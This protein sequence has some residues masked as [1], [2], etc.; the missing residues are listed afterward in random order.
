MSAMTYLSKHPETGVYRF[1]RGIPPALRKAIGRGLEWNE[2]LGTKD[3][4]VAKSLMPEVTERVNHAFA[5]VEATI[6]GAGKG[7]E[8]FDTV[9]AS[10]AKQFAALWLSERMDD[11][12]DWR[13]EN[14]APEDYDETLSDIYSR[15]REGLND[16]PRPSSLRVV[17]RDI[18]D[19]CQK[20]ELQLKMNSIGYRRIGHALLLNQRRWLEMVRDRNAGEWPEV[21]RPS[22][23]PARRQSEPE[24]EGDTPT[25]SAVLRAW[26]AERKP[27]P[28]TEQEWTT[29]VRRWKDLHG[30]TPVA[31]IKKPMVAAFKDELLKAPARPPHAIRALPLPKMVKAAAAKDLR[32]VSATAV[33]KTLAAI[34]SILSYAIKQGQ[35][36]VNPASGVLALVQRTSEDEERQSFTDAQVCMVLEAALKEKRESDRWLPWMAALMGAR[37]DEMATPRAMD[38]MTEDGIAYLR[39]TDAGEGRSTKNRGSRRKMPIHPFL[40][41]MGFLDYVKGLPQDGPLFPGLNSKAYTPRFGR[42]LD[43]IG[44]DDPNL[45]FHSFRH[46]FKDACRTAGIQEEVHDALTGHSNVSVGRKYGSRGMPVDIL[47]DAVNSVT[48]RGLEAIATKADAAD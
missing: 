10:D 22:R 17:E 2:S 33:N 15:V 27:R 37:R 19:I 34:R 36:E 14:V 9:S 28:R 29:A 7:E 18:K 3:L 48:Y 26:L 4:R 1:R 44:L 16:F 43:K 30:D 8:A 38:L 40:I 31:D 47:A 21:P 11:D 5:E 24:V 20:H 35:L 45:V 13:M 42:M 6:D 39:I 41:D 23:V 46:T 25:I 12:E 32:R